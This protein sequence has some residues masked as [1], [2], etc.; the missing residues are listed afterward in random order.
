MEKFDSKEKVQTTRIDLKSRIFFGA[1]FIFAMNEQMSVDDS[2]EAAVDI[3][4]AA[5]ARAKKMKEENPVF[6]RRRFTRPTQ[7]KEG[8]TTQ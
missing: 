6:P 4:N 8:V 3:E 2:I 5:N 1:V 7:D